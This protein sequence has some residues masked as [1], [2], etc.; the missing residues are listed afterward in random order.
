MFLSVKYRVFYSVLAQNIPCCILYK[1]NYQSRLPLLLA[2]RCSVFSERCTVIILQVQKQR[3]YSSVNFGRLFNLMSESVYTKQF[4][5]SL[6]LLFIYVIQTL[7]SLDLFV[8]SI[9][10]IHHSAKIR[11]TV[12]RPLYKWNSLKTV[13]SYYTSGVIACVSGFTAIIS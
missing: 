2:T 1:A 11:Y 5:A 3:S 7:A 8:S 4:D 12:N 9:W 10:I 13:R 6:C